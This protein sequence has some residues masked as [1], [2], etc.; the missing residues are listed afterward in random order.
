MRAADGSEQ[1]STSAAAL[2]VERLVP[3]DHQRLSSV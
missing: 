1:L 3:L 2:S